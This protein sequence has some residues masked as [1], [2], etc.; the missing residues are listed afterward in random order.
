MKIAISATGPNIDDQVETRFGRCPYFQIIDTESNN[1]EALDNTNAALG[2]GAGIQAAEMLVN[3]GVEVVL[4]GACGPN[5]YQVFNA[6]G[7]PV[8]VQV[9]GTV[10]QAIEKYNEGLYSPASK[11]SVESHY[12]M[13][14]N[15]PL[16]N[17]IP[18]Q[19]DAGR[20]VGRGGGM[21]GMGQGRGMG[22]GGGMG[23]GRGM[24]KGGGMG[25]GS[26]MGRRKGGNNNIGN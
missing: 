12:G 1:N 13:T 23:Q 16:P 7:V 9:N 21:G 8:I 14:V 3:R 4:T 15:N 2:G 22:K 18:R 11:P 17:P 5:A 26:G 6:A 25:K 20:G 24:G 19:G 10:R